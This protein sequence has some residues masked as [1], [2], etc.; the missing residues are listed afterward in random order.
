MCALGGLWRVVLTSR[1]RW[2]R[3]ARAQFAPF[4]QQW[5]DVRREAVSRAGAKAPSEQRELNLCSGCHVAGKMCLWP[6]TAR[7]A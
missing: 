3:F 4:L 6:E 1:T 2:P 5:V 7:S